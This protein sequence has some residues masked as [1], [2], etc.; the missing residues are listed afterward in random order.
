MSNQE[1]IE[2]AFVFIIAQK[3]KLTVIMIEILRNQSISS[4]SSFDENDENSDDND[5]FDV[6]RFVSVIRFA[7]NVEFFN[8]DYKDV[9]NSVIINVD[10]H[11]F[12]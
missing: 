6:H 1:N 7:K 10:Q 2:S 4:S 11:V 3:R 12:Y 8:S 9:N 5:D